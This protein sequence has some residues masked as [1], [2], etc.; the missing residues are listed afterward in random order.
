MTCFPRCQTQ[1]RHPHDPLLLMYAHVR[2]ENH[3]IACPHDIEHARL[4]FLYQL[5]GADEVSV[6]SC[7]FASHGVTALRLGD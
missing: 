3:E 6:E 1:P 5:F 4:L 2:L 7:K